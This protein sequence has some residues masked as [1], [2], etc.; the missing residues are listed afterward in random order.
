MACERP[1]CTLPS[2][3]IKYILGVERYP[4][5]IN[6]IKWL[7]AL[8]LLIEDSRGKVVHP[9]TRRLGSVSGRNNSRDWWR[10]LSGG[11]VSW[12]GWQFFGVP[13]L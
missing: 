12:Y 2:A 4:H 8:S 3:T 7:Y 6:M 11:P 5:I 1:K 9:M 13:L 10:A